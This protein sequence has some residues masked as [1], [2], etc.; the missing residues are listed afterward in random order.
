MLDL[1]TIMKQYPN[2]LSSRTSFKSILMD[3][4][5]SEKRTVNILT[6]LFECGIAN[7]IKAK[8]SIDTN[9]MH[10][11]ITQIENE[12]GIS[13]QY[14]QDAI[15]IWAA[16]FDVTVSAVNVNTAEAAAREALKPAENKPVVYVQGNVDDYEVVQKSDGYYI[17]RFNGFEEEEMTIPSMIDGKEIKGIAENAFLGCVTVKTVHISEGIEV[18]ENCAFKKCK[19]LENVTLP[20]TLRRIGSIS[21]KYGDGAFH[22]TNLKAITVPQNVEFL[23]PYSFGFCTHLKKIELSN[24]ITTIHK[25]TFTYCDNLSEIKLP[26]KLETIEENAF[27]NCRS[28]RE[29][30][31]PIGTQKIGE[32]AFEGANITT[33]YI[34]PTVTAIGDGSTSSFND[35]IF[36]HFI[37][38]IT[39]YCAAGSAAMDYARKHNIRCARAQF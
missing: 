13:G 25:G 21:A 39:I 34:P 19:S 22:F 23:G 28:L 10:G 18:I 12:F 6:I 2:C 29:I 4:Y 8:K 33:I 32:G 15:M 16:A 24:Q 3:T 38:N 7:K 17:T 20:D 35:T 1:K 14:S 11:L 37:G 26:D 36:G 5:P 30:H 27:G 9:E 31:I